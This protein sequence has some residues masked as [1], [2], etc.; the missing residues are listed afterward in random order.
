MGKVFVTRSIPESGL[1]MIRD[2]GHTVVVSEKDRALTKE[3]LHTALASDAYDA[4]I[5]LITDTIDAALLENAPS[6]KLFAQYAVGYDNVDREA[7]KTRGI[8]LTN[9]PDVLSNAVAEHTFALLLAFARRVVESDAFVRAQKFTGWEPSLFLGTELRGK[10]LG[11]VGTGRIGARVAEIA[12]AF[13]MQVQ[14]FDINENEPLKKQGA[15]FT[16]LNTIFETSDVVS[17]HVP[18]LASTRHLVGKEE[19]ARMRRSAFLIN[20]SRGAIIDE[21]ALVEALSA[22]RIRG[23]ALDV[24]ENE[25]HLTAGLAALTNVILTPHI[26]SATIETRDAMSVMVAENV[27]AFFENRVPPQRVS[28]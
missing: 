23:A 24:F 13:G 10:T 12:L 7:L 1:A 16:S 21:Q 5:C 2:A 19:L 17:L 28:A 14:C 27:L 3:E 22:H 18:L 4:V 15:A 26:A 11:L 6:V 9:T 8:T 20:T 25:P